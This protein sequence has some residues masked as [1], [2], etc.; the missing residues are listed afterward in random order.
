MNTF[1]LEPPHLLSIQQESEQLLEWQ[2]FKLQNFIFTLLYQRKMLVQDGGKKKKKKNF[3]WSS[4]DFTSLDINFSSG[5]NYKIMKRQYNF[6][7]S[8]ANW[9]ILLEE[10][11]YKEEKA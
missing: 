10:L 2:T 8:Q 3:F 1:K 4:F 5:S 9:T 11:L 7:Y 6:K